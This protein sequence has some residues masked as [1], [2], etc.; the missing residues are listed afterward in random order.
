VYKRGLPPLG[1]GEVVFK[2]EGIAKELKPAEMVEWGKIKRV[3]GVAYTAR[4]GPMLGNRAISSARGPDSHLITSLPFSHICF[5]NP[6]YFLISVVLGSAMCILC[7]P[8]VFNKFLPDV[9]I[10]ADNFKG[11]E[12]GL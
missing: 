10:H 1:G 7:A 12:A 4:C 2:C 6:F 9:Y 5:L 11:S 8:G 3:R